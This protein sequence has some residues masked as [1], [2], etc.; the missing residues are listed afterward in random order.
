MAAPPAPASLQK[1]LE[2]IEGY[3]SALVAFSAGVDSTLVLRAAVDALG[4]DRVLGVTGRSPAVPPWELEDAP[5]LAA[6]C[7]ARHLFLD[8]AEL[9]SPGYVANAPDRCYHCKSELFTRLEVLRE[10][11][12][13]AWIVD[14]TNADDLSDHRPGMRARRENRVRSPLVEAGLGKAV[15]RELS[16]HYGLPTADKPALACLASRF[17]YGTEVTA[18]GLAVVA[19]AERAVRD[20]G[21]RQFRVRHHGELARLEVDPAELDRAASPEGR[22]ALSRALKGAGYRWV[23]LDLDGY[24]SGSLNEVLVPAAIARSAPSGGPAR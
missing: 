15:V 8:T 18:E 24:R 19:E 17:P 23:S 4:A 3:G 11:E 20:L 2:T 13:L 21:Y 22:E 12:G 9:E 5:G 1:L 10:E 7:G 6:T 14:G 16:A